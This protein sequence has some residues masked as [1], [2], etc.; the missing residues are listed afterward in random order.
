MPV[1][2]KNLQQQVEVLDHE[3]ERLRNELNTLSRW[4]R[5]LVGKVPHPIFIVDKDGRY[6]HI[7]ENGSNLIT[8]TGE[9]LRPD[10]TIFDTMTRRDAQERLELIQLAIAEQEPIKQEFTMYHRYLKENRTYEAS[11]LPDGEIVVVA[12]VDVTELHRERQKARGQIDD[13]RARLEEVENQNRGYI[14]AL[15]ALKREYSQK[16]DG[17]IYRRIE[18]IFKRDG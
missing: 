8:L 18:E 12:L 14:D 11:I 13:L 17:A 6:L 9:R 3:N 7:Y 15:E 4:Y 2:I 5:L 1:E 10:K 16:S